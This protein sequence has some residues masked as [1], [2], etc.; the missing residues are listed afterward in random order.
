MVNADLLKATWIATRDRLVARGLL[1]DAGASL[2]LRCPGSA[3]MWLGKAEDAE[4]ERVVWRSTVTNTAAAV[5]AAV[6]SRRGDVGAIACGGGPFGAC[7]ADFGG[8]M[9]QVFDEQARHL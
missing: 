8:I 2:S 7:L 5:Q 3:M 9:P 4:P 1:R 6:Y